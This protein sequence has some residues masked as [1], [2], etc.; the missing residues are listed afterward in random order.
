VPRLAFATIWL[1]AAALG[2]GSSQRAERYVEPTPV[3][4]VVD[5]E[6]MEVHPSYGQP[7][8]DRVLAEEK[9]A[10]AQGTAA[11]AG[12]IEQRGKAVEIALH[13]ADLEVQQRYIEALE[14]CRARGMWC[15]PRL[16]LAWT[17]RD[18]ADLPVSLDAETRFDLASWRKLT[19][20]LWAR[21]CDCRSM[22]CVDAMTQMIDG[23]ELR[24][25]A[26]VQGDHESSVALTGARTC[27][28]RLRGK[29]GKRGQGG[30]EAPAPSPSPS[31]HGGFALEG[32]PHLPPW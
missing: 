1:W 2:C 15:P 14:L 5:A 8:M 7:E 29:A 25:T 24:P 32:R 22:R 31:L 9:Q 23:L 27:L 3:N 11:L 17:I 13:Q 6:A 16:G 19:T 4:E 12:L 21:G 10:L 30:A 18:D 20:E 28:W 26:E